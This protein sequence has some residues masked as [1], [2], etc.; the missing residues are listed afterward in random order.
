MKNPFTKPQVLLLLFFTFHFAMICVKSFR[1]YSAM[2]AIEPWVHPLRNVS[3]YYTEMTVLQADYSFF[4]PNISPDFFVSI[5]VKDLTGNNKDASFKFSNTE[6]EKRFHTCVLALNNLPPDL[7]DIMVKSWAARTLDLHPDAE[8]ITVKIER[9]KIPAMAKFAQ[10]KRNKPEKM[11]E[12]V[13]QTAEPAISL[14]Q[15]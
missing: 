3:E 14:S 6:V 4:S 15:P 2:K 8:Q 11:L 7:Q 12:V 10:G 9:N 5:I 1:E 13:F